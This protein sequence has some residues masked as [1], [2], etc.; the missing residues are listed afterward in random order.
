MKQ[1]VVRWLWCLAVVP[2]LGGGGGHA[3]VPEKKT[4]FTRYDI[5]VEYHRS[6][7]YESDVRKVFGQAAEYLRNRTAE[8][9][10]APRD[11][12]T[13]EEEEKDTPD[14]KDAG[15]RQNEAPADGGPDGDKGKKEKD[16]DAR[17]GDGAGAR[18]SDGDGDGDRPEGKGD[19]A[20]RDRKPK[21][22]VILS[23]DETCLSNWNEMLRCR[24]ERVPSHLRAWA[25]ERRATAI[26]AALDFFREARARKVAIFLV[27]R[28]PKS[29][30]KD[31]E[32]NL[33][34]Q[35]F[36]HWKDLVLLP[37][38]Y[39]EPSTAPFK[40]AARKEIEMKGYVIIANIGDHDSDLTGGYA[41]RTFKLPNPFYKIP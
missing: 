25:K 10:D 24:F 18:S 12:G 32:E 2:L 13:P 20:H 5:F 1:R 30:K 41:E 19:K 15:N 7:R 26:P 23:V 36:D 9:K 33:E 38:D 21:L 6:G 22:A 3:Q 39:A 37:D 11:E 29:L 40:T 35:G 34:S 16:R 31:T 17:A 8:L 28:R 14:R 27:T 4:L